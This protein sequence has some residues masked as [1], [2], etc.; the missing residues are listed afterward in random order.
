MNMEMSRKEYDFVD[1]KLS[2]SFCSNRRR[3]ARD[4]ARFIGPFL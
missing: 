4:A 3:V 1:A 2:S